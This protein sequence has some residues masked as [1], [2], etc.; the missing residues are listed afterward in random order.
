M[1]LGWDAQLVPSPLPSLEKAVQFGLFSE[2]WR[3]V[4]YFVF[5]NFFFFW[6]KFILKET[7]DYTFRARQ[8]GVETVV[9]CLGKVVTLKAN[10]F[11]DQ[12]S[13]Y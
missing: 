11:S 8:E 3:H 4:K 10:Q 9:F 5:S 12:L 13:S 7:T 6:L 1:T 2:P